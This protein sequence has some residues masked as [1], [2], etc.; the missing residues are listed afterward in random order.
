MLVEK[1]Q[2]PILLIFTTSRSKL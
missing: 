1:I 2:R